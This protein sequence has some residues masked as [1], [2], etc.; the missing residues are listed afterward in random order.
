MN[1]NS[2]E[3]YATPAFHL[4]LK[5]A[6]KASVGICL[7]KIHLLVHEI[8]SVSYFSLFLNNG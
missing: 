4:H 8:L 5:N 3:S 1:K 2:A 6:M 7:V